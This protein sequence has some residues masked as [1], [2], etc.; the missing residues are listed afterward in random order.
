VGAVQ[1]MSGNITVLIP[2]QNNSA[3][4]LK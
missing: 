2:E 3:L 4:K 1:E